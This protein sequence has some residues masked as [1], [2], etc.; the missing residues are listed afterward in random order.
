MHPGDLLLIQ[1][2]A[3]D[4]FR[5]DPRMPTRHGYVHF[6]TE[7]DPLG[8]PLLRNAQ[9]AAPLG[10]M[11]DYL[12]WLGDEQAPGWRERAEDILGA[13]LRAFVSGPL[14]EPERQPEPPALAAALDHV[15]HAWQRGV[16]AVPLSELAEAASVSKSYL[17][18]QFRE[19]YGC[20]AVTALELVRLGRART[21]LARTNMTVTE[22]AR[23]CG[24]ADPLHFS[25]RFKAV[26]GVPPRGYRAT[27]ADVAEPGPDAMRR[28]VRRLMANGEFLKA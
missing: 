3:E 27:P 19:N 26:H 12:V 2:G 16:R 23:T 13:T 18:R 6:R 7:A 9:L 17:A 5:W 21:L 8:W 20:G 22:V 11:L 1:P 14:P 24:F 15:R 4:E 10:G 25:R 28:L